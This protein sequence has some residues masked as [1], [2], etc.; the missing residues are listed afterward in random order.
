[1][2]AT[3]TTQSQAAMDHPFSRNSNLAGSPLPLIPRRS[4]SASRMPLSG[5]TTPS[6]T[7]TASPVS[8][9]VQ[10]ATPPDVKDKVDPEASS[11]SSESSSSS[12]SSSSKIFL[13]PKRILGVPKSTLIAPIE[14]PTLA[15]SRAKKDSRTRL[16][17]PPAE[18]TDEPDTPRP[19]HPSGTPSRLDLDGPK[20]RHVSE[21]HLPAPSSSKS[22]PLHQTPPMIRKKS[23]QLVKSSLKGSKSTP[24]P[25]LSVLTGMMSSKSEPN[26][27]TLSKAVHFD[28]QLEHV[29]LFLAE[30]KPLAVSRDGSPTDDTSGTDSDFPAF[31]YGDK[32]TKQQLVMNVINMPATVNRIA[33]VAMES[34]LL[35]GDGTH[36][37]GRVRVR[38]LAFQKWLAVRFT[39]DAWQTT[40]EVTAKYAESVDREFDIFSFT[41]KLNDLLARI[42]EKTLVLA[43]RYSVNGR[44]IWDNNNGRNYVAKFSRVKPIAGRAMASGARLDISDLKAQLEKMVQKRNEEELI[45][46]PPLRVTRSSASVSSMATPDLNDLKKGV[47]LSS[48]YDIGTSLKSSW[49]SPPTTISR[50]RTHTYPSAVPPTPSPPSSIPWPAKVSSPPLTIKTNKAMGSPRDLDDDSFRP[51]PYVPADPEDRPFAI[52]RHHQRGYFD[53]SFQAGATVKRTPPGTPRMRSADD[54]TPVPRAYSFPPVDMPLF[55]LSFGRDVEGAGSDESTPS[56]I[57][58][59]SSSDQDS[60][61][62]HS[63]TDAS[64]D[65]PNTNY[66]QF[67]NRYCFYTGGDSSLEVSPELSRSSSLDDVLSTSPRLPAFVIQRLSQTPTPTQILP[68]LDTGA[69]TPTPANFKQTAGL[70]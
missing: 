58:P 68:L 65:K 9:T 63:P 30:Q 24:R 6:P 2:I 59:G 15:L 56:I 22:A 34:L 8:I 46:L 23:G 39:F 28:A 53:L 1:M 21:S 29:K 70:S 66:H 4:A 52:A 43:L 16:P 69:M 62:A 36:I 14:S 25:G 37:L 47:T 13:R 26:T 51:A 32:P 61:P 33:D 11:S 50:A 45:T 57:S 55:A 20:P 3:I 44:E 64:G 35:S 10:R 54:S 67:L 19:S 49:K 48:R 40:S 60:S 27:P 17:P 41:V 5:F 18:A 31:I 7:Q 12:S 42:E 38:N